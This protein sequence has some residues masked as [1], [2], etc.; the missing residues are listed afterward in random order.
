[1]STTISVT[2]NVIHIFMACLNRVWIA[3]IECHCCEYGF[4][5]GFDARK[6]FYSQPSQYY[7]F[8]V[9]YEFHSGVSSLT[10]SRYLVAGFQQ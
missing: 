8:I 5:H 6:P 3:I 4:W 2:V 1:M 7:V 10:L 9:N